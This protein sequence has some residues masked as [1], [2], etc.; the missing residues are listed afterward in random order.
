MKIPSHR[1]IWGN[2]GSL[3]KSAAYKLYKK[4]LKKFKKSIDFSQKMWYYN[5]KERGNSRSTGGYDGYS[6]DPM[7][8][9][10]KGVIPMGL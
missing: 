8:Y 3:T 4:T 7:T 6:E 2:I 5:I 1:G 9:K 10:P